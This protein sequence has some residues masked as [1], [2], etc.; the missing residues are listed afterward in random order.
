M[1][2]GLVKVKAFAVRCQR[3][4][5]G[6]RAVILPRRPTRSTGRLPERQ[7]AARLPSFSALLMT[8]IP[9]RIAGAKSDLAGGS[10]A[11]PG[12][13]KANKRVQFGYGLNYLI[14]VE[15]AVIVDVEATPARTYDEVAATKTM[16]KRTEQTQ[17]LKPKRRFLPIRAYGTASPPAVADRDRHYA[18]YSRLG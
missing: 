15:R 13:A 2:V 1:N 11:R 12:P 4:R 3:H 14:D 18:S 9:R 7:D 10:R 5:G 16:I 8:K 6:T 17:G